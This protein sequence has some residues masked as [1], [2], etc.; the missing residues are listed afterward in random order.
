MTSILLPLFIIRWRQGRQY[1]KERDYRKSAKSV[2]AMS[3]RSNISCGEFPPHGDDS[4]V[5]TTL[6]GPYHRDWKDRE[7][8]VKCTEIMVLP[9][10]GDPP[11][12]CVILRRAWLRLQVAAN[13]AS[14][15]YRTFAWNFWRYGE[16]TSCVLP[17]AFS[18]SLVNGA[19][20]RISCA[21]YATDIP[22]HNLA[23]S[24]MQKCGLYDWSSQ[25]LR[26]M[27][28]SAH[29]DFCQVPDWQEPLYKGRD[30]KKRKERSSHE[31]GRKDAS[32]CVLGPWK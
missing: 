7:F 22:P 13:G 26:L 16:R 15:R 12:G 5:I 32:S 20:K 2:A 3:Q 31:T 4:S 11:A 21:G 27:T 10:D 23:E 9:M 24:S 8:L 19:T 28:A 29:G 1:G 17:A 18:K 14:E 6:Y 30:E 25:K